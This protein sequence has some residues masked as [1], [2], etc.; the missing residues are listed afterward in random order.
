MNALRIAK[1]YTLPVDLAGE[2]IAIL[3][4]RGAGKTNTATVLVE[5]LVDAAVQVVVLDPVGAWWGLRSSASGERAGLDIPIL[6]GHHGDIPLEQTAGALIADVALDTRRSLVLDLSELPSKAAVGRF[7]TDF[8]ER[9]YRKKKPDSLLHLVL[10][11]ADSFAPQKVR[12]SE[13]MQGAIEQIVRRGRS[14]GLG[15]TLIT[16]RSAVLSKDVLTQ[17]DVLI[18]MRTT[19]PHDLRAIREWIDS[20]GDERGADVLS[21]LPGLATGEAWIWNP[22]RDILDRVAVRARSTFD[23]SRTPRAGETLAEPKRTADI[24]LA[25]LGKQMQATVEKAK[26]DDPAELRKRIRTLEQRLTKA[27]MMAPQQEE[28]K[29]IEVEKIVEVPAIST[30]V[31]QELA[32]IGT[33]VRDAAQGL[34]DAVNRFPTAKDLA[35]GLSRM[36]SPPPRPL[37]KTK[38]II[39]ASPDGGKTP[40]RVVSAEVNGNLS[41][42]QQ[43]VVDAVAWLDALSIAPE[44][45][46]VAVVAGYSPKS[47]GFNNLL[48]GLR[49]DGVLDYPRPGIVALT[50]AGKE[51]A[52]PGDIP[53]TS[54]G[55]QAKI[56]EKLSRPQQTV[57]Q[58]VLDSYPDAIEKTELAGRAGYSAGSGGY[59]NLLGSLRSLGLIDYP[60]PGWVIAE[61]VLFIH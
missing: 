16:Q 38:P 35:A 30:E 29:T 22:E 54:E 26:A 44:K 61:S 51:L 3:A 17:A 43:K 40:S 25:K 33:T 59:N 56:M 36:A 42:P 12:G 47:G 6:G 19:G 46:R 10:E 14:R 41:R 32:T 34:I 21:S 15:V 39:I 37:P 60:S 4:K 45:T 11:E 48:G 27:E 9:L 23:S 5:E 20:R 52:N 24:D 53:V 18:V 1:G 13:R 50:D 49:S 2:T 8:A 58:G 57:L 7:V 28:P 31:L 55:I